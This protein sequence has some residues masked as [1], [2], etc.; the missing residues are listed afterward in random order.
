MEKAIIYFKYYTMLYLQNPCQCGFELPVIYSIEVC[1]QTN[2]V[3]RRQR[4]PYQIRLLSFYFHLQ[5][6][7][8]EVLDRTG[9]LTLT[10]WGTKWLLLERSLQLTHAEGHSSTITAIAFSH[11]GKA[12][13]AW[14]Q[15]EMWNLRLKDQDFQVQNLFSKRIND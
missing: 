2:G 8:C 12:L 7:T 6:N 10:V 15:M 3:K 1:S 9:E 11:Y 4:V 13:M 14:Q 5:A